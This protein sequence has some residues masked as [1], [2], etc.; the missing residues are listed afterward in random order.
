MDPDT[1]H[2]DGGVRVSLASSTLLDECRPLPEDILALDDHQTACQYCGVSYLLL[3]KYEKMLL[4]VAKLEKHLAEL[5]SYEEDYPK[6][7]SQSVKLEAD[8]QEA[9]Q[10]KQLI[11]KEAAL[12][13]EEARRGNIAHG[14]NRSQNHRPPFCP[15]VIRF[16]ARIDFCRKM[17]YGGAGYQT[18]LALILFGGSW[19]VWLDARHT[20]GAALAEFAARLPH[21]VDAAV[22]RRIRGVRA[23]CAA[24]LTRVRDELADT[25]EEL[26]A[27]KGRESELAANLEQM[28]ELH[29]ERTEE[30]QRIIDELE[31]RLSASEEDC[32][33]LKKQH[34][35]ALEN[36]RAVVEKHTRELDAMRREA[37]RLALSNSELQKKSEALEKT[38]KELRTTLAEERRALEVGGKA[39]LAAANKALATKDTRIEALEDEGRELKKALSS[40][41]DERQKMIDAHQSRIA[42]LQDKYTAMLKD[43]GM[44]QERLE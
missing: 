35:T 7:S 18:M 27:S 41:R 26:N 44:A 40:L 6:L 15:V 19:R 12:A 30:K 1:S 4:H 2:H 23:A 37:S 14:P 22:E 36:Q 24:D 25:L 33:M 28:Q 20:F 39:A 42:Q 13:T 43:A 34:D 17:Y 5:K 21:A 11:E 31:Q 10:A 32:M 38:E 8:L 29:D 3:S 16:A 9:V